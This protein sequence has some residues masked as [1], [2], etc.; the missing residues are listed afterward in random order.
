MAEA[1]L[2][3]DPALEGNPELADELRLFLG[4]DAAFLQKG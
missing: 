3:Q 2:D 4:E 1:V